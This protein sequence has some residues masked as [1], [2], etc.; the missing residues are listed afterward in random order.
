MEEVRTLIHSELQVAIVM[1]VNVVEIDAL[2]CRRFSCL[3]NEQI[4]LM[5][6]E[7]DATKPQFSDTSTSYIL[8]ESAITPRPFLAP[9]RLT[10]ILKL[11]PVDG[12]FPAIPL[13][14]Q[15]TPRS[16]ICPLAEKSA[17]VA[18]YVDPPNS[19]VTTTP[20]P[21]FMRRRTTLLVCV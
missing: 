6:E 12:V 2:S 15:P 21:A 20:T 5:N 4:E 13:A 16:N 1:I 11:A 9:V 17:N 7:T 19:I 10:R 8:P 3:V 14:T 18:C